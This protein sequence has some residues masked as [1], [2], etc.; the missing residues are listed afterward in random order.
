M[1]R[2]GKG[3]WLAAAGVGGVGAYA[4]HRHL[5]RNSAER[6]GVRP[7]VE[8]AP[9]AAP[10]STGV[11]T[12]PAPKLKPITRT[13]DPIFEEFGHGLPLPYLRAL[14]KRE[15]DMNPRETTGPAW[16]LMQ[17]VEVVR[18]DFNKTHGTSF[19]RRDLLDPKTNVTI[20]TWLLD[21]ITRSYERNH[22]GVP[23]L[24][25][26]WNNPR[27]VELLTFGWN[28]GW[29]ES[30]GLG[31]VARYLEG[32]GT[33]DRITA[34]LIHENA[35]A[36][37]AVRFLSMAKRLRWSKSVARYYLSERLHEMAAGSRHPVT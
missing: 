6:P 17:V 28:S 26:D 16:G 35:S 12:A 37:G 30:R 27:F 13:F 31:R 21:L 29:S 2:G 32:R 23:N 33:H 1:S 18:R 24:Q 11:R 25:T 19:A 22:P 7:H 9:F 34:D 10:S 4:L 8:P 20:A 15:S 36:A 14:A 5:S 3:A